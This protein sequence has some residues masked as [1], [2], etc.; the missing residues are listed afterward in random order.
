MLSLKIRWDTRSRI[1]AVILFFMAIALL[2]RLIPALFIK[3]AGFLYT[4]DT[5]GWYT[6][7]QIE[8]MVHHFPQYN[9]F[10]PMTAYPTGKFIDW[11]PLYPLIAALFCLIGG[12]TSQAAIVS[13]AG[14]VSPIMAMLMVPVVY[15]V[16]KTIWDWRAG[17]VAA[18]LVAV[19]SYHYFFLSSYGLIG[20]HIAEALFS[21]IFLLVYLSSLAYTRK[22]GLDRKDLRTFYVPVLLALGGGVIYFCA[23]LASQTVILLLFVVGI[24]TFIQSILDHCTGRSSLDLLILNGISLLVSAA[25]LLLFGFKQTGFSITQYSPGLVYVHLAVLAETGLLVGISSIFMG[26]RYSYLFSIGALCAAGIA[27]IELYPPFQYLSAQGLGLIFGSMQYSVG[28]V[29]TQPL[30]LPL[31][32]DYFGLALLLTV[33]GFLVLGY[34]VL[35][36]PKAEW[37]FLLIWSIVMLLLTVKF[38]RFDYYSTVNIVLLSAICITEPFRWQDA[39]V[40]AKISSL[41]SRIVPAPSAASGVEGPQGRPSGA[42]ERSGKKKRTPRSRDDRDA[43]GTLKV[44]CLA[45]VLLLTVVLVG[46]SVYKDL[47]QGLHTPDHELSPDWIESLRWLG[48][49]T[50]ATGVDYFGE[51]PSSGYRY[52]NSWYGILASWD[53]GHWI[54]FFAHRIPITN[55]FQDNLAGSN[56]ADAFFLEQNE[57]QADA[58]LEGLGGRYVIVDSTLAVDKFTNLIPWASDSTDIS[59]YISWFMLPEPGNTKNLDKVHRFNDGYFQTVVSRLYNF[60]GSMT[61]PVNAEYIPYVIRQVPAAG[62]SAGDVN[63]YARVISGDVPVDISSGTGNLTLIPEGQVLSSSAY[64]GLY[65]SLPYEPVATVPALKHYRLVHESPDN[66][67]VAAFPESDTVMLPDIKSVKVFEYVKGAQITGD[68]IIEVH[69]ITNTGRTFVYR[70]AS[71]NGMFT[72]PYSTSG[73]SCEVRVTGP[74]HILGTDRYINVTEEDVMQGNRIS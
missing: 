36:K 21:T 47:D 4:Y 61:M 67:S 29:E 27:V 70:Q 45:L 55:P 57:P 54:T 42:P 69:V 46:V 49:A 37:I 66:A 5:D 72:V 58:I 18:G 39:G 16:G 25:L 23:L 41:V 11:G 48:N 30:T 3:D 40:K 71:E 15:Y 74:Y 43:R 50:P 33:G 7:R 17:I 32:W 64:A 59:P 34:S 73:S 8:V 68:G 51:Y 12:A 26:K 13:A 28:V 22:Y 6:L 31:A 2:L 1:A 52:P 62:E 35:K 44:L 60:D 20:H 14:W 19:I 24:F 56:G 53:S 9:W 63:G 65:S 10:D 38:Q